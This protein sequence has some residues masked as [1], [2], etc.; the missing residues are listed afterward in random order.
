[1]ADTIVD[2][3]NLTKD[4]HS[5]LR[6]RRVRAVTDFSASITRGTIVGFL[7]PNGAGK[8]TSLFCTLGFL[9]PTSGSV[10][11]FGQPNDSP[12]L[13]GR[14]GF[15]SE[16]Y[17]VNKETTP[18]DLLTYYGKLSGLDGKPLKERICSL[19]EKLALTDYSK[20]KVKA[21]SKGNVQ[22]LGIAQALLSKPEL[23]VLD[24]PTTGL[25]PAGRKL[26][27][28]IVCKFRDDGGTIIFSSHT[29]PDVE[30][31]CDKLLV[32]NKGA[33][34]YSGTLQHLTATESLESAYLRLVGAMP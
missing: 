28:D 20:A 33:V 12:E 23:L 16:V 34:A 11:L 1:M 19:L 30:R 5:G 15:V 8:T 21:L 22:R 10:T 14:I 31:L 4:Y 25:D 29:L 13:L 26:F 2:I 18:T 7:G 27:A 6:R 24:E 3:Q 32:M 17:C 9:R